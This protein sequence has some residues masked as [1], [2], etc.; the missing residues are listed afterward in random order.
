MNTVSEAGNQHTKPQFYA[1]AS[2]NYVKICA[3]MQSNPTV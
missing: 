2:E 1:Q 3:N